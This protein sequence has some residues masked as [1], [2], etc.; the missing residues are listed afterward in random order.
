M[1]LSTESDP[2][3]GEGGNR[4]PGSG[5]R[6]TI[7]HH[8]AGEEVISKRTYSSRR[9]VERLPTSVRRVKQGRGSSRTTRVAARATATRSFNARTRNVTVVL[10]WEVSH[11]RRQFVRPPRWR[12]CDRCGN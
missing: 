9:V 10:S 1:G 3:Y 5:G 2:A 11:G 7:P 6:S 12:I 8:S 4:L